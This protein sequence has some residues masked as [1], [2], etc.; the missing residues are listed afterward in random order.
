MV[1]DVAWTILDGFAA[2]WPNFPVDRRAVLIG[3]ATHDVGK[4]VYTDEMRGPGRQHENEGPGILLAN[5]LSPDLARFARTHSQWALEQPPTIEDLL[6][7]LANTVWIGH[8]NEHLENPIVARVVEFTGEPAWS[9]FAK[10]DDIILGVVE[11]AGER[12][13]LYN[14]VPDDDAST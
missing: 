7:A 5:G 10:V 4:A 14:R 1:H 13:A 3:A 11:S 6:V 12:L 9:V 2:E 8:R